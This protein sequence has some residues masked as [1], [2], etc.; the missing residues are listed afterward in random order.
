MTRTCPDSYRRRSCNRA[1][2]LRDRLR[3]ATAGV[4][5]GR[6]RSSLLLA[7]LAVAGARLVMALPSAGISPAIGAY[8]TV[9]TGLFWVATFVRHRQ[10]HLPYAFVIGF[11]VDRLLR[12]AGNTLDPSLSTG[13]GSAQ[14]V[15]S[16]LLVVVT[17][18]NFIR[19]PSLSLEDSRGLFTLWGGFGLGGLL[20]LQLALLASPNASAARSAYDYTILV[21]AL[22]AATALPLVPAVQRAARGVVSLFDASVQ[23]W[24]WM[25]VLALF[26]V[27]GTRVQ[28]AVGAGALVAAQFVASLTWWW[29]V[30]PQ[31]EKERNASGLWMLVAVVVFGLFV[32]MDLFTFEYAYVRE[33]SGQFAFLNR[34]VTPLLRGFRGLGLA[35]LIVG[36][37][38]ASLPVI[39]SRRRA[40]WRDG[41]VV[42]SLVSLL[43]VGVLIVLG[44]FLSRPPVVEPYEGGEFR[45]GTYNIHAGYNEFFHSDLES[46]A[47]TIQQSGANVVLLQEVEAGRLTSFGVDQTLWLARKVGM[48][49][50][51]YATNEGLQ[52]LAVLSNVEIV[53]DDGVPL[54]SEGQQTGL[55]RVVLQPD[56]RPITLYNTWLGVLLEGVGDDVAEQEQDQV[57]Q[58][59][60]DS[61]DHARSRRRQHRL[62]RAD[63]RGR[64]V[65][66]R[67]IV[68]PHSAD[69]PNKPDRSLCGSAAGD[70]SHVRPDEPA[71]AAGLLVHEFAALGAVVIDSSASDHRLAVVS[72]ALR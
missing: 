43:V 47:R 34:V 46:L 20:F 59:Q 67:A 37:V 72:L 35:V 60:R 36:V 30:R 14:I 63:R 13:Y 44:A 62:V 5:L 61:V 19:P 48:D 65:Q 24:V 18:A 69:A 3:A 39:A 23:G 25:L 33:L 55:Q 7:G 31:A 64:D 51:F 26:L 9:G 70:K 10:I 32:V 8:L 49:R 57:R 58:A 22:I 4:G 17:A 11:T 68:R 66:Q 29:L 2:R 56:D 15:L 16:A 45:I 6:W 71:C 28:G 53:F 41:S 50:R 54:T 40:A 38:T 27:V 12:A 1:G 42:S 52:G 21:P